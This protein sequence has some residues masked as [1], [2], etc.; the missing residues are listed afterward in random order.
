MYVEQ[1]KA[2]VERI[3]AIFERIGQPGFDLTSLYVKDYSVTPLGTNRALL[4]LIAY[5]AD[6]VEQL[7]VRLSEKGSAE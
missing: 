1:Q 4:K 5:L 3:N 2:E 6:E 7:K